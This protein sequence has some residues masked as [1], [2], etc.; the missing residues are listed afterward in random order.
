MNHLRAFLRLHP[1]LAALILCAALMMRALVP[2]GF[3]PQI[4]ARSITI[5]IC[6]DATGQHLLRQ[7][8]VPLAAGHGAKHSKSDGGPCAF[9]GMAHAMLGGVDGWL[10]AGALAFIL[11]RGFAQVRV[12]APLERAYLRPPLRGPP[13]HA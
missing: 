11:L 2:V 3:M 7:I 8:D 13:L 5:E 10:L 6:A 9:G 12:A 1:G 4:G